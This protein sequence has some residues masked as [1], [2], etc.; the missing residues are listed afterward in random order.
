MTADIQHTTDF[1]GETRPETIATDYPFLSAEEQDFVKSHI[2]NY[3]Y[4]PMFY[5]AVRYF[6]QSQDKKDEV[7]ARINGILGFHQS[8]TQLAEEFYLTR[9]RVRQLSTMSV[10]NKS[11]YPEVWDTARWAA[12][13]FFYRPLITTA[14]MN[15]QEL[16]RREALDTLSPYAAMAIIRQMRP[17][18]IVALK[19]DGTSANGRRTDGKQWQEPQVLFLVQQEYSIYN[20]TNALWEVGHE[21]SL[22]LISDQHL[23][24]AALVDAHL[25]EPTDDAT[26][27]TIREMMAEVLPMFE[28]VEVE[29]DDITL[30]ANHMNYTEEIYQ[31][32]KQH[33]EAM[34][35]EQIFDAFR[36]L[37]PEDHHTH[38]GFIRSYMWGDDRFE[39]IGRKSTY[40]LKEWGAFAGSLGELAIHL[41]E[42]CEEPMDVDELSRQMMALRSNT[43]LKSCGTSIYLAVTD[44]RLLYYINN[45]VGLADREYDKCYWPSPVTVEGAV[46]SMRRFLE[47]KQRWPFASREN[48]LETSLYYTMR[49]YARKL[50]VTEEEYAKYQAAMADINPYL[51]PANDHEMI[52]IKRCREFADFCG[53]HHRLPR[54][55]D[56]PALYNWY[57]S[58]VAQEQHLVG[59]RKHYFQQLQQDIITSRQPINPLHTDAGFKAGEQLMLN[60]GEE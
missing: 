14:A 18:N 29:G 22:K 13:P 60:F 53:K 46:R 30:K 39:A 37:H 16:Y 23:S 1:A 59:C 10:A 38:S 44:G 51:Y 52:F 56:N 17:M 11:P 32:M 3:G 20:F 49:K 41:L 28:G 4:Y 42:Q 21:N 43:T 15:W 36:Q 40:Q 54:T 24:V 34:T 58:A 2:S 33:G 57:K 8:L 9:E 26:R 25:S 7:I 35:V 55:T 19:G 31:I 6:R 27:Q 5:I 47:E 12:Y 48:A 45:L 50:H